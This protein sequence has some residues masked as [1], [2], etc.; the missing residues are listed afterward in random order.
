MC[1]KPFPPAKNK[2]K[3][4]LVATLS[5]PLLRGGPLNWLKCVKI[6]EPTYHYTTLLLVRLAL[7][8]KVTFDTFYRIFGKIYQ[9]IE[10]EI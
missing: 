5:G 3:I 10:V 9:K 6:H 4:F 7:G 8:K 2:A 1:T